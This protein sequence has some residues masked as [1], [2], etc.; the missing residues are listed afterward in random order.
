M[1]TSSPTLPKPFKKYLEE[2]RDLV[3]E[4]LWSEAVM[5]S[6]TA[7]ISSW[8][9]GESVFITI[10][11]QNEKKASR[12][13]FSLNELYYV[14]DCRCEDDPC[15]H[16]LTASILGNAKWDE[17]KSSTSELVSKNSPP[18]L[19]YYLTF[20]NSDLS[21]QRYIVGSDTKKVFNE[22]LVEYIGGVS[23]GRIKQEMPLV[24]TEDYSIDKS[25]GLGKKNLV[26]NEFYNEALFALSKLSHVYFN[27]AKVRVSDYPELYYLNFL[28]EAN[29]LK[30]KALES[31]N[32]TIRIELGVINWKLKL[33][34][35][36]E[37]YLKKEIL[38]PTED[39][40]AFLRDKLPLLEKYFIVSPP[41]GS[42]PE[43]IDAEPRL[44]F[45]TEEIDSAYAVNA[46]IH[47]G[48]CNNEAPLLMIDKLSTSRASSG[49]SV[50]LGGSS[51]N[52][53]VRRDYKKEKELE[54]ELYK[55]S[56][57]SLGEKRVFS[58]DQAVYFTEKLKD[59]EVIGEAH[60][61]YL[62][63][64]DL[65]PSVQLNEE[66]NEIDIV[67]KTK[68]G[69]I[70][71]DFDSVRRRFNE[72]SSFIELPSGSWAMLPKDFLSKS[73]P[74]LELEGSAFHEAET[75]SNK[76]KRALFLSPLIEN[77]DE[78]IIR[79]VFNVRSNLNAESKSYYVPDGISLRSYQKEGVSWV[80]ER[81]Q[82][83]DMGVLLADDMG[84]GKTFQ[85]L[86][87][88]TFPALII[89][90]TSLLSQWADDIKNWYP[91][92]SFNL[93][94]GSDRVWNDS[95]EI[96][97]STYGILR[98][99][100]EKFSEKLFS[101]IVLD[102][103]QTIKNPLSNVS[104]AVR[105]LKANFRLGLSG[106]PIENS[107]L[108]LWSVFSFIQ[109]GLLPEP[110]R[111]QKITETGDGLNLIRKVLSNFILR[112]KKKDVLKDLPEKT[113]I[114]VPCLMSE[115]EREFYNKLLIS[116]KDEAEKYFSNKTN[117][118]SLFE[119]LLRLRQICVHSSLTGHGSI[120]NSS[121]IEIVL[122]YL[123]R[124]T[125]S[126]HKVLLFSQWTSALDIIEPLITSKICK[127]L[128]IDGSTRDRQGVIEKFKTE[129]DYQVLLLSLK[130]G[131]VGLNLTVADHVIFL[132]PWWNPAVE[133]QAED[134]IHR[135]G[136]LNPVCIYRM[137]VKDSIEEKILEL[138]KRK[139]ALSE[140]LLEG[141]I[142]GS[143]VLSEQDI[144]FLLSY[145]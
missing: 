143:T 9:E 25:L 65:L 4:S 112:R 76:I 36:Y 122:D 95:A 81:Q 80:K 28:L 21:I 47:Y 33:P 46:Q 124:I 129:S 139:S 86:S 24:S 38:I 71:L 101:M 98:N 34:E 140:A 11:H 117:K 51:T 72:G 67:F 3:D 137:I 52:K 54:N 15:L 45:F 55:F 132:D 96:T 128:R 40:P 69:N 111:L 39:I 22:S 127:A 119:K 14:S 23:S 12:I 120:S 145:S 17:I 115:E 91:S 106:T 142:S 75:K 136:Q 77:V 92:L 104:E 68:D 37:V 130:A 2:F 7:D 64:D 66:N 20:N 93:Y 74:L 88:L 29:G 107:I 70:G 85:T 62:L 83:D 60:R 125:E 73:I 18:H 141:S 94:H 32:S 42:W 5:L 56:N 116:A 131:G 1:P 41:E 26:L 100:S 123:E 57:L 53:I 10:R 35:Q 63:T 79:R 114:V 89:V 138:H 30:L 135:I 27:D 49:A 90:P 121:K 133:K 84:L 78:D 113:E 8:C 43:I 87:S 102:E 48:V 105:S 82:I 118:M 50:K 13:Q 134:R 108:D 6:R 109:A 103:I 61:K 31:S 58:G 16:L 99:E 144:R 110:E 59:K 97:L 126:N 19:A 44:V